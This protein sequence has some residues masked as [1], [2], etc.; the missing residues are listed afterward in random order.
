MITKRSQS[1]Y[2]SKNIKIEE[3]RV[4]SY[5]FNCYGFVNHCIEVCH[6]EAYEQLVWAMNHV[7]VKAIPPSSDGQ[8]CPFNYT[9]ALTHLPLSEWQTVEAL[10]DIIPGDILV[11]L[12]PNFHPPKDADFSKKSTGTHIMIVDQVL[13]KIGDTYQFIIIDSTRIPH[14]KQD[15]RYPKGS[16]IGRSPV[17]LTPHENIVLL[18][19]SLKGKKHEKAITIGRVLPSKPLFSMQA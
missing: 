2:S 16:G 19:W 14:S 12:P 11:Y 17:F 9:S 4:L 8:P 15:T 7:L 6:P 3:D 10:S 5:Q 13:E 1:T 18:Q